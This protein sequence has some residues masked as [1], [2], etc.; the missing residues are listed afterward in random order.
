MCNFYL[1]LFH[2]T[3]AQPLYLHSI[4][5]LEGEYNTLRIPEYK[6]GEGVVYNNVLYKPDLCAQIHELTRGVL[7]E[8]STAS[9]CAFSLVK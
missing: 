3:A 1:Q 6:D 9:G 2:S 7:P 8:S 4:V 5:V